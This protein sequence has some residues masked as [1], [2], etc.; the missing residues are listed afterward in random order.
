[1]VLYTI[2]VGK[3]KAEETC[4]YSNPN[5]YGKCAFRKSY[6]RIKPKFPLTSYSNSY[7][8]KWIEG[9]GYPHSN[10]G[11]VFKIIELSLNII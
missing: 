1:M 2:L 6:L 7:D 10:L 5:E 8:I 11:A 4:L 3:I 9:I